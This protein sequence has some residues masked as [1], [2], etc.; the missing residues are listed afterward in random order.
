MFGH[1]TNSI[2]PSYL[3]L[4]IYHYGITYCASYNKDDYGN[5]IITSIN[6]GE[7]FYNLRD[8]FISIKG[9]NDGDEWLECLY[10]NDEIN[11]WSPL[12]YI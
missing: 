3:L 7:K 1:K 6:T 12:I 2:V 11:D 9:L 10:Y 4:S 5:E 8:F